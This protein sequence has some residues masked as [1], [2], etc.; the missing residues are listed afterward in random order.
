MATVSMRWLTLLLLV[1]V[2]A[3][4]LV[5]EES[6]RPNFVVF[7][8][9]DQGWGD[10]ACYGHPEIQSP[11]LDRFASEGLRL[12]QCYAACSVCSPS[13]SAIL[14]GRTPYRNGVWRWIPGGSQYHLRE[15][16][17]TI[18]TLLKQRGYDTCHAGKWH[19]N[20]K[21]NSDAQPQPDDHG[22]DHWLATQNNAS[23][24]HMNPSNYVRNGEPVGRMEGASAILAAEEASQWLQDRPDP[25]TP[26]FITVWTHEPHLPIE[27]APRFMEPYAHLDDEGLRQHHGNITQLDAAFGNLMKALDQQGYRDNTVVFF[28]SDNGPEGNGT[29]G[30]TRGS[31]GGLRG[32][33]RHT[34]EG[35]IRV[36]G[37]I[38][39]P[40]KINA[41]TVSDTPVIGSDIFTTI[42]D[43]VDIPLPENRTIDGASLLPLFAGEPVQRDQPL[44]WRNHLAREEYRVGLRVG[45]WKIIGSDDLSSF[46]LYNIARDPEETTDL[47]AAEPERFAQLKQRLIQHDAA[48]LEE[49]PDWWKE[50][51]QRSSKRRGRTAEP[52]AG[53]D[54]TGDFDVVLGATLKKTD[55]GYLLEPSGEGLALRKLDQPITERA[56]I[57]LTYRTAAA[58]QSTK[59]GMLVI[60]DKPTNTDSFKIGTAI[61][62]N[63]HVAFP[64]GWN[65][66]GAAAA[67][68]ASFGG[69]DR[70]TVQVDLD[71]EKQSA[72]ATI[73]GV[74]LSIK[75]PAD[76]QTVRY[77]GL[78]SKATATEFQDLA[79]ETEKP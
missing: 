19:L 77:I 51:V 46:E 52:P 25:K 66:V 6:E 28:T 15:S 13:R 44:Y 60:S 9:D 62:M 43:I 70:F 3:P 11:N 2:S 33:K 65:N 32:R 69:E 23:P 17:I 54:E 7:L 21:F 47:S 31:T 42:C 30:R 22:Y 58:G 45:D 56:T 67:K 64:G 48:V 55:P 8:T 50:D 61:G 59:N 20:G 53:K 74:K 1:L 5:A 26:F 37:I 29:S 73:N 34:H 68:R 14:T 41:G 10:L 40:G 71:L 75:L 49:G 38:R 63:Q 27:S 24:N 78:Y 4:A 12:T 16:E 35:G 72:T 18:A 36:P 79:I 76:L 39:W 57:R